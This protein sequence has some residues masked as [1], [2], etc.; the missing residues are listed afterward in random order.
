VGTERDWRDRRGLTAAV[1]VV[2]GNVLLLVGGRGDD[3]LEN[4]LHVG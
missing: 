4:G 3:S 2:D 1:V